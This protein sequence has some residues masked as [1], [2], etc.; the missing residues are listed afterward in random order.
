M[1]RDII[2]PGMDGGR[3]LSGRR[4]E[5]LLFGVTLYDPDG[6]GGAAV[7]PQTRSGF[8]NGGGGTTGNNRN[9]IRFKSDNLG[10]NLEKGTGKGRE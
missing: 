3:N 7:K 2:K 8:K 6:W 5:T 4:G 9:R 10:Q 1:D